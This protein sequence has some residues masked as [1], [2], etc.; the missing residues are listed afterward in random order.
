MINVIASIRVREG[1]RAELL[2]IFKANVPAV[3]AENGCIDYYPTVDVDANFDHPPQEKDPDL[4]TV[5]EKWESLAALGAHTK[6]SHML[7]YREKVKDLVAGLS[8]KVLE[9]G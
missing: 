5:I 2:E 9:E 7:A 8:I 6:A 1:K 4:V 3:R